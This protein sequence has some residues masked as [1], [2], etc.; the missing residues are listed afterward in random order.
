VCPK[1]NKSRRKLSPGIISNAKL[2]EYFCAVRRKGTA[3]QNIM[4]CHEHKMITFGC[5]FY[6][7]T[8]ES[9]FGFP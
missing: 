6:F 9:D 8:F 5:H 3:L 7:A 1:K 2:P 4:L